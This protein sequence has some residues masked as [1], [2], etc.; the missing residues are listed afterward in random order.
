MSKIY[1]NFIKS[2]R[3][4]GDMGRDVEDLLDSEGIDYLDVDEDEGDVTI[5]FK[6]KGM[7]P[8]AKRV[9]KD[10]GW[11]IMDSDSGTLRV[12]K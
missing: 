6:N 9:L 12:Y 3:S 5:T 4:E 10:D 2:F 7:I 1:A 11:N 8:R